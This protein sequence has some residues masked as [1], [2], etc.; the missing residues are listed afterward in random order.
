LKGAKIKK[1][2]NFPGLGLSDA[3][4]KILLVGGLLVIVKG[5]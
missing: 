1:A 4:G 2:R 5:V 3:A